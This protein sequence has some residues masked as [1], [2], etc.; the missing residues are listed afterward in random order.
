[1]NLEEYKSFRKALKA[2]TLFSTKENGKNYA[3]N[4]KQS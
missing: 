2:F 1:M 3:L 4:Y